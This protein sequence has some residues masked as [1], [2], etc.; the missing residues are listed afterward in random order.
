MLSNRAIINVVSAITI[1]TIAAASVVSGETPRP[2]DVIG[3]EPGS[4]YKLAKWDQLVDYYRAL[5]RESDRVEIVEIG[6]SVLQK[7]LLLLYISSEDNLRRLDDWRE[8]SESLARAR[9]DDDTARRLADE[10]KA[11]RVARRR[12]SR[13]RSCAFPDDAASR[14]SHRDRGIRGDAEDSRQRHRAPH[15]FHEPGWTRYRGELVPEKS[16]DTVRDDASARA[17]PPLRRA[18]QQPRL[19]HEQHARSESGHRDPLQA[20]VPANRLQPSSDRTGVGAYLSPA[21]RRSRE[22]EHPP[23]CH[24]GRQ[25]GRDGDGESVSPCRRCPGLSPT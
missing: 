22:P 19:V 15:A 18:R 23:G 12:T 9:I 24:H 13:D 14:V 17:L 2:A 6:R 16:R 3:F 1:A 11:G 8:M 4:D 10:G 7:P 25:H 5:D 21:V 20:V